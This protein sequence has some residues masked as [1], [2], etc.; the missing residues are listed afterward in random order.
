MGA[1]TVASVVRASMLSKATW[2]GNV[3]TYSTRRASLP[4]DRDT[5]MLRRS[6]GIGPGCEYTRK[7]ILSGKYKR[8][9]SLEQLSGGKNG[10]VCGHCAGV[11]VFRAY[12]QCGTERGSCTGVRAYAQLPVSY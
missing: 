8:H 2:R 10:F 12:S 3:G 5:T 1:R 6:E 9:A 7:R 11:G 4:I